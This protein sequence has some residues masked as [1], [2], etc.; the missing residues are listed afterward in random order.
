MTTLRIHSGCS[1]GPPLIMEA[2][3][4]VSGVTRV[5]AL[6]GST[7]FIVFVEGA[8]QAADKERCTTDDAIWWT[9]NI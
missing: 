7:N 6:A 5:H 3:R 4:C 9:Q 8:D 2:L 1:R